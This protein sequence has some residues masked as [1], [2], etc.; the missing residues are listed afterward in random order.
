VSRIAITCEGPTLNDPLDPRFGRA[1]G[2]LI[3]DTDT[4][5]I[6]YVE[7]GAGQQLSQGAGIQAAKTLVDHRVSALLTGY[8]GP[9]AF[10][11]LSAAGIR[12]AQGLESMTAQEALNQFTD[13]SLT[14]AEAPN[15][16]GH[17]R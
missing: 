12:V 10:H 6:Q 16:R 2:F 8:V 5:A 7:N 13:G 17:G 11:A 9:K 14:W 3:V 1:A 4:H 15:S